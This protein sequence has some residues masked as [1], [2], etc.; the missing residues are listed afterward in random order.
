MTNHI[1]T[2]TKKGGRYSDIGPEKNIFLCVPKIPNELAIK[3][4]RF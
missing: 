1:L 3:K 4:K 2:G